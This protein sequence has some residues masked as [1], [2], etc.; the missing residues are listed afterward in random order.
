[1]TIVHIAK[2]TGVAGTEN[3]LLALLRGLRAHGVD[4]KLLVL[5]E[6]GKALDGYIAHM[7]T[8]GVP[9]EGILIRRDFDPVLIGDLARRLT[10]ATLVHT[11]LIHADIHGVL[12]TKRAGIR[13]LVSSGHNDDRFRHLL[14]IRLFQGWFWR[15]ASAGIAISEALRQFMIAFEFA[16]PAKVHTVHYGLDPQSIPVDPCARD[17]L[18]QQL[19]LAPTTPIVGS[20]CRLVDQKGLIYA[21][22]AIAKVHD[23]LPALHYVIAGDGPL[24]EP[25]Q[26]EAVQ[27]GIADRVHF[28]GW[29]DNGCGLMQAYDALLIPSLWEG[30]GLVALEAMAARIPV[31]AS[32]VSAL[33]EIVVDGETG[34]LVAPRD[35]DGLAV[36]IGR[37]YSEGTHTL[38]ENGRRRLES[39][40]T[41]DRMVEKTLAVYDS[42]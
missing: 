36:A 19:K 29:Q 20:V 30:F 8:L 40:F 31:I 18:R 23:S 9:A 25:L 32:R 39:E 13:R 5:V 24:R 1:M 16:P 2:M 34:Y 21:L 28:L 10:G 3:H 27:F 12:A 22:Q 38:G 35:G 7:N 42:L 26:A 15:Q 33:P 41:V 4:L 11:H 17:A 6:P 14:P 37:L